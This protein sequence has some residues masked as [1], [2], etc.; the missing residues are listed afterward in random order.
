MLQRYN[1]LNTVQ[2]PTRMTKSTSS[3]VD[4][5]IINRL[6]FKV[7]VIIYELGLSDHNAQIPPIVCRK[8]DN[9]TTKI[10][11]RYFNKNNIIKFIDLLIKMSWQ[12]VITITEVNAKFEV[13]ME[14]ISIL[15]DTAFPLKQTHECHVDHTRNKGIQYKQQTVQYVKEPYI[16]IKWNKIIYG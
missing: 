16:T 12:E 3:V 13:F 7:P 2:F 8:L 9:T 4:L 6:Q 5:M 15:F 14:K 1:L 10:W 11:R